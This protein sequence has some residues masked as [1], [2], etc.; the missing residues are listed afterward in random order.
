MES[1][2]WLILLLSICT[3][4][5]IRIMRNQQTTIRC[6]FL[7]CFSFFCRENARFLSRRVP[8]EVKTREQLFKKAHLLLQQLWNKD[9]PGAW[10]TLDFE[11]PSG[12]AVALVDQIKNSLKK[13]IFEMVCQAFR[14]IHIAN[15]AKL[16]H[17]SQEEAM[18]GT[19]IH[20][21]LDC[22]IALH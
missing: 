18:S 17:C 19:V 5:A 1:I 9:Y 3:F 8:I 6:L 15:L 12:H 11:W 14:T 20:L 21:Y 2:F 13:R 10:T 22:C 4:A 7:L 16:L